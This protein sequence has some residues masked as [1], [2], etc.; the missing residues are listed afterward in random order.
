[1]TKTEILDKFLSDIEKEKLVDFVNDEIQ[2]EAVKKV[3]LFNVQ[4]NGVLLPGEPA[5]P[6]RNWALSLFEQLRAG[7]NKDQIFQAYAGIC[8]GIYFLESA[9]K[10]LKGITDRLN[11]KKVEEEE[12]PAR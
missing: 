12:N 8:E 3:L 6:T 9:L 1:M 4:K 7:V 5:E 2:F 11:N 10:D